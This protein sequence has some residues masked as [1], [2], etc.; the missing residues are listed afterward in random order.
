MENLFQHAWFIFLRKTVCCILLDKFLFLSYET[1]K[2][3]GH[4][5]L[6][7][8]SSESGCKIFLT[9]DFCLHITISFSFDCS[10]FN[11]CIKSPFCL[12]FS[13]KKCYIV[14]F[15]HFLSLYLFFFSFE[16]FYIIP[17]KFWV[18]LQTFFIFS[19]DRERIVLS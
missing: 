9:R 8:G 1:R 11:Y 2:R 3:K 13:N 16:F 6:N 4:R 15:Y 19:T 12:T 7:K 14:L 18:I 5:I 10:S 17:F